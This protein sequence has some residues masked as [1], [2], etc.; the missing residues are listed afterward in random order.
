MKLFYTFILGVICFPAISLGSSLR[1][2]W[3]PLGTT[4]VELTY[5]VDMMIQIPVFQEEQSIMRYYHALL[6]TD[7]ATLLKDLDAKR[8]ALLLN[9]WMYYGL[10]R[11]GVSVIFHEHSPFE[12]ELISWFLMSHAGF[13]TRL[14]YNSKAAYLYIF[15]EEEVFEMPMLQDNQ[16]NYYHIPFPLQYPAGLESVSILPFNAMPGGRSLSFAWEDYPAFQPRTLEKVVQ[17][18]TK[19]SLYD[20][21]VLIDQTLIEVMAQQPVIAET[22]YFEISMS[23]ALQESLLPQ[24]E[25]IMRG[26]DVR[27]SLE[28]LLAFTRSS[29]AYMEDE[30]Y[31]GRS[32]PMT[33][34][35]VFFYP[36]SD[37]EDRAVLFF[38]TAKALLKLPMIV[39]SFSDH[40][41]L[42]IALPWTCRDA[43][44][45]KG[46]KYCICD[47]TG[48]IH[49]REPGIWPKG[50]ESK[51]FQI[52]KSW[53]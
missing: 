9:D 7:Y 1:S 42:G 29:F 38:Q 32:K 19:D 51:P 20:F 8:E 26:K 40:I 46:Q 35:E 16:R 5:N 41:T 36:F 14:A 37:C 53:P 28:I 39:I 25:A 45:Y 23:T 43:V 31:F 12:R 3:V 11:S 33:P 6:D 52:I 18:R 50:Y 30:A 34:D 24:L 13:D 22:E 2:A 4:A 10:L 48:P 17:L 47:P 49:D 27:E 44:L 21:T 15:S